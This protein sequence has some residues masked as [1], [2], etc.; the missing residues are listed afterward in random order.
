MNESSGIQ[1]YNKKGNL[2]IVLLVEILILFGC[3]TTSGKYH[4]KYKYS[5]EIKPKVTPTQLTS[6]RIPITEFSL[7]PTKTQTEP[8]LILN[9]PVGL[10]N[11][12]PEPLLNHLPD[13]SGEEYLSGK[14]YLCSLPSVSAFDFDEG[15]VTDADN[16]ESLLWMKLNL[17]PQPILNVRSWFPH[18]RVWDMF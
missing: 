6:T 4:E 14:F 9:T 8:N 17:N 3:N 7:K 12:V 13:P 10:C 16:R 1:M 11:N 15:K 2:L 18:L 5:D